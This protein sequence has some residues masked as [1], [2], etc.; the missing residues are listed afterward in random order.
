MRAVGFRR[1]G[2][3]NV[4]EIVE[5][6]MPEPGPDEVVVRVHAAAVNPTDLLMRAGKQAALMSDLQPPFVPGMELAGRVQTT[7]AGVSGLAAGAPV[8]GVVDARRVGGGAQAQYVRVP[9]ASLAPISAAADLVQAATV[10][11]N[12]LTAQMAIDELRLA[13]GGSVLITGGAGAVGG[14]AIQLARLAGLTVVADA[15]AADQELVRR[16]GADVV[17][18]RGDGMPSAVR[19]RFSGGVDGAV[20]AAR[21]GAVTASVVR[22]GGAAIVM[23]S[24]DASANGRI[25]CRFVSVVRRIGDSD[26]LARLAALMTAGTLTP[27]VAVRLPFEHAAEGHRLVERGGL[28]GRVVLLLER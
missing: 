25:E 19:E 2:G 18:P 27:R 13:P 14:Y 20:D 10:P 8:M 1:F 15:S 4:L 11:M 3:P 26:A 6:P 23:R 12:G 21:L 17:V 24:A 7:G 5:L 16:L 28:R 9:R 22:D